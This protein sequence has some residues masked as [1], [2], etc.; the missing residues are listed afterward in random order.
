VISRESCAEALRSIFRAVAPGERKAEA[1]S[2]SLDVGST[3]DETG[4]L[5]GAFRRFSLSRLALNSLFLVALGVVAIVGI[6]SFHYGV[7][8][9]TAAKGLLRGCVL[10]LIQGAVAIHDPCKQRQLTLGPSDAVS[11]GQVHGRLDEVMSPGAPVRSPSGRFVTATAVRNAHIV[12]NRFHFG[13]QPF[14]E[15]TLKAL[16]ERFELDRILAESHSELETLVLVRSWARSL[17]RRNDFHGK[18]TNFNALELPF[19]RVTPTPDLY[20]P[21]HFFPLLYAQLVASLGF[22]SRIV[23]VGHAVVEVWS[24]QFEKWILMDAEFDHHFEKDGVPLNIVEMLEENYTTGE[25]VQLVS[26]RRFP[27]PENPTMVHLKLER[28]TAAECIP[29]F[30][31]PI[32]IA[33]LRNDWLT[34]HYFPGHPQRSEGNSLVY[35]DPRVEVSGEVAFRNRMR[36]AAENKS[37]LY[38]TLNQAE[39]LFRGWIE[40]DL[41]LEF[42]TV[43]PNFQCFEIMIDGAEPIRHASSQYRWRLHEGSNTLAVRPKNKFGVKGIESAVELSV[44]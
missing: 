26:G 23:S 41:E 19:S 6:T 24:N 1:S 43:T 8:M 20:D 16:R 31:A 13:Y 3:F 39:I 10:R 5:E 28:L 15:P 33:D 22:E 4:S 40:N 44:P 25:E 7:A 27:M 11:I 14:E 2:A 29:W 18:L 38:W 42:G 34:N 35:I 9:G 30:N 17:Y 21:C 12:R 32:E 36:P 37:E